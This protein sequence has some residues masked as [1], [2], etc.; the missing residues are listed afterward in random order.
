MK[1]SILTG[2]QATSEQPHIGNY[3]GAI[4]PMVELQKQDSHEIW[5][6]VADLHSIT[7]ILNIKTNNPYM[8]WTRDLI[9]IYIACGVDLEKTIVFKQSDTP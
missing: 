4:K 3:F 2:L 6:F 5:M 1:P 8:K 7:K 9:K